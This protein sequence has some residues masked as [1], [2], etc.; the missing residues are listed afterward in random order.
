MKVHYLFYLLNIR[1]FSGKTVHH[2]L[3]LE[4]CDYFNLTKDDW[5]RLQPKLTAGL[6]SIQFFL[7]VTANGIGRIRLILFINLL[8][9]PH[10]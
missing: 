8:L 3:F 7:K 4:A 10:S 5:F 1:F 2:R 6:I 9:T